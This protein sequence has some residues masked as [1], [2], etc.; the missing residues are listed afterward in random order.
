FTSWFLLS[1]SW[2]GLAPP[3]WLRLPAL[4]RAS[5]DAATPAATVRGKVGLLFAEEPG[6]PRD[7]TPVEIIAGAWD[8][9]A[10][11]SGVR[12]LASRIPGSSVHVMRWSGHAGAYA[13]PRAYARLSVA[14]LA[15]L[16]SDTGLG[17]EELSPRTH[18]P[19]DAPVRPDV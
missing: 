10:P 19:V 4:W 6:L 3:L 11:L 16:A 8:L 7:G 9:V 13:R 17:P 18:G 5:R 12:R 1:T 15:R 2:E 14:L